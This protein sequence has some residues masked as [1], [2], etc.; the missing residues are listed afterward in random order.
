MIVGADIDVV[1]VAQDAAAGAFR[2]RGHEL[3][4]RNRRMAEA[5][6]GGGVFHQYPALHV[7]LHLVDMPA[8]HGERFLGHRQRQQVGEVG[9]VDH[10]PGDMLGHQAGLDPLGHAA[11]AFEMGRIQSLGAAQ[12]QPDAVQRDRTVAADGV[13]IAQRRA[14]A[15][16]V[17]GVD[18]HPRHVG[19]TVQHRLV[20]LEAQPYS[21]L[22]RNRAGMG[23][24]VGRHQPA[25]TSRSSCRLES[26][27]N[28]RP[29]AARTTWDRGPGSIV[30]RRNARLRRNRSWRR[31]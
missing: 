22:C 18:L 9:A 26:W 14:A 31:R 23:D 27:R 11:D 5:Q 10:A 30:R 12:R 20:M 19:A 6:I 13:E 28:R 3:P 1:H 7:A 24:E 29:A 8:H 25:I 15:H 21:G 2:H 4:F 16:V 17:L